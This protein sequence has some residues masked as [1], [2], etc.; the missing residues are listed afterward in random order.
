[1]GTSTTGT[2]PRTLAPLRPHYISAVDSGNLAGHLLTLKPGLLELITA[3]V[4][5]PRQLQGLLDTWNI[6]HGT[7][8]DADADTLQPAEQALT[9]ALDQPPRRASEIIALL[10]RSTILPRAWPAS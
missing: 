8:A 2:T 7:L 1:M 10:Q 9:A 6:L 4:F 3:P 5:H